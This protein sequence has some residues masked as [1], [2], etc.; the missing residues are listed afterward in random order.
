MIE[1]TCVVMG[2]RPAIKAR[3]KCKYTGAVG[4]VAV[5]VYYC[6]YAHGSGDQW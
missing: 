4:T 3:A 6:G 1:N 5:G 2:P